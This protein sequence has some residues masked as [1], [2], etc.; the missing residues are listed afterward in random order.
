MRSSGGFST[1]SQGVH[2]DLQEVE[3]LQYV[4]VKRTSASRFRESVKILQHF[5]IYKIIAQT[6][7]I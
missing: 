6:A 1:A 2:T 3:K 4:V 5:A 7:L